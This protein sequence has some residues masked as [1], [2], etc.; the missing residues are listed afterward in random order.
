MKLTFWGAAKQVTGSMHMLTLANG[1]N[2]LVDCGMNYDQK[3]E[4]HEEAFD[5]PFRP[6]DIDL[7]ILTHAH[8]DHSGNL[9][10]LVDRGYQGKIICTPATAELTK[11][12]LFDSANIQ[13]QEYKSK[14]ARAKIQKRRLIPKPIYFDRNVE[15]MMDRIVTWHFDK[16]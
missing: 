12:L 2:I 10:A 14:L 15:L 3:R 7:V 5:F 16:P 8:I 1:Y 13:L 9:P 4:L 6:Q 11:F